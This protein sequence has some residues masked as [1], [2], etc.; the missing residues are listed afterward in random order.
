MNKKRYSLATCNNLKIICIIVLSAKTKI[1]C[2]RNIFDKNRSYKK[3]LL[4]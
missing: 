2:D 3:D 1:G 4:G